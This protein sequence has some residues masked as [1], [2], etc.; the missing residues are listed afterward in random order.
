[1]TETINDTVLED[2]FV[3]FDSRSRT[4]HQLPNNGELFLEHQLPFIIV[5]HKI[6]NDDTT[7]RIVKSMASYLII[8]EGNGEFYQQLCSQLS[9]K[10][11]DRFGSFLIF[12]FIKGQKGIQ[13]FKIM[14][15][16]E[17]SRI[18]LQDLEQE[19]IQL[20]TNRED[21]FLS[22]E[23]E[24]Y[25]DSNKH[26]IL[27][28]KKLE[29]SGAQFLQLEI[30]QV[31]IS[32]EGNIYPFYFQRFKNSLIKAIQKAMH[33]FARVQ[34]SSD[35]T[36]Y[37]AL[38]KRKIDEHVF[39]IDKG[40]FEIQSAYH[41]LLLVSPTNVAEIKKHF[42][43]SGFKDLHDY[44]YRF[45]P[46]DPNLLKRKLFNLKIEDIDDPALSY[47]FDEKR[48]EIDQELT[49][50]KERGTPGFLHRSIRL[51]R[52][53]DQSLV[54]E[55]KSILNNL[56]EEPTS[57]S[58]D[59]IDANQFAK[60][61]RQEFDYFKNQCA[62]F[63][64]KI[65]IRDDINI[66]MV[67]K[68][69]LYLP[70]DSTMTEQDAHALIQHEIGTHVLTYF[71]GKQQPLYQMAIGWADYDALQEGLAVFSEY[72]CGG[73][74]ANRLRTIAGRV[75]AGEA[76]KNGCDFKHLFHL[77]HHD[78]GFADKTAFNITT[79]VFQGGGFMK[80]IIY[81]KGLVQVKEFI[82]QG[83][84]ITCLL[85]GKFAIEH[86][87]LIKELTDRNIIKPATI[88]P[89]YLELS[90]FDEKINNVRNGLPL[91]KLTQ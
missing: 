5:Y 61:A 34:T 29:Q 60:L 47:L 69:E 13:R 51:Y 20:E 71:N 32:E 39:K 67:S 89:R 14:G 35:I 30:P 68:G 9:E 45:M 40:I 75:I 80:D 58:E 87:S 1:M 41:F 78:Y 37:T 16:I 42:F 62:D 19:L 17:K 63:S 79:R 82:M 76:I 46:I 25:K 23:V 27:D 83:G 90:G 43:A 22:V 73:L 2:I 49:M 18:A 28:L 77:L 74:S 12:E 84:D 54:H 3:Q 52:G 4:F 36:S 15:N 91:Y 65:H 50:L 31:F 70:S 8:P 38:G 48:E 11:A 55:A 21:T 64:S 57:P 53:L 33:H 56:P 86:V 24:N 59:L 81:L 85:S 26:T 6:E 10:M 7:L 72:L 44:H 88:L 66:L